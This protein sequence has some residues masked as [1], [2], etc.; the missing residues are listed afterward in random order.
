MIAKH[1]KLLLPL[2]LIFLTSSAWCVD[3][4]SQGLAAQK[5]GKHE[6]AV[7]LLGQYLKDHQDAAPARRA[8]AQAL[9][10]QGRKTEALE[11]INRAL[12]SRPQDTG[13]LL[14]QGS[15]LAGLEQREEAIAVFSKILGQDP[16]NVEALKERGD[17]LA[18][19]GRFPEAQKD[20]DQAAALAPKDP[21]V[22]FKR[23]M[24]YFCQGQYPEAVTDFSTAIKLAPDRGLFYFCRGQIYLQHLHQKEKAAADFQKGCRLESPLCCQELEKMGIKPIKE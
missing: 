13:L 22:F 4:L 8:L 14:T 16:K 24:G 9:N 21:W 20:Y 12:E 5:A 17:N 23:G 3:L 15:I 19:E 1:L 10:D 2:C 6:E 7:K 11:E 18:Q